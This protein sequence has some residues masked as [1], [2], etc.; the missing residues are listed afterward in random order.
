MSISEYSAADFSSVVRSHLPRQPVDLLT[1]QALVR[2]RNRAAN[3][4]A[5]LADPVRSKLLTPA[6]RARLTS[7]C[8]AA[9]TRAANHKKGRAKLGFKAV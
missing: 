8:K 6:V 4:R 7:E 2:D 3:L 9:A 1:E 5:L